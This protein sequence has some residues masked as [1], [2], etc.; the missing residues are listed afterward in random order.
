MDVG[1][2]DEDL[3]VH[4]LAPVKV[5]HDVGQTRIPDVGARKHT[6]P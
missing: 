4:G 3:V 2:H 5:V 1:A 6:L